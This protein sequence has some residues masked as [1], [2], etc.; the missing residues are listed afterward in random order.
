MSST[1]SY[2]CGSRLFF[3]ILT[4]NSV[5]TRAGGRFLWETL[6]STNKRQRVGWCTLYCSYV[7]SSSA[8]TLLSWNTHSVP[9]CLELRRCSFTLSY[10]IAGSKR[11][12]R[13]NCWCICSLD[14]GDGLSWGAARNA[15]EPH[16]AHLRHATM[17]SLEHGPVCVRLGIISAF[18]GLDSRR[19]FSSSSRNWS[20]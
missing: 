19:R 15:A 18:R 20:P 3:F 13:S 17:Q 5:A 6:S 9:V 16:Y 11:D 2:R 12:T 10:F 14:I 7:S 1:C 4:C 8:C